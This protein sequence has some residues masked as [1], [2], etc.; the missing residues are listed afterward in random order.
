MR[1]FL[2]PADLA[3]LIAVTIAA[4]PLTNRL[5]AQDSQPTSS[6]SVTAVVVADGNAVSTP[7]PTP[8]ATS[9]ATPVSTIDFRT[10]RTD[11]ASSVATASAKVALAASVN[12]LRSG[13]HAHEANSPLVI[14]AAAQHASLG[15]SQALM[16]VG[17]AALIT[18][19]I[20]GDDPGTVIMVG[21]AIVGLYGLYQYLQ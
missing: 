3:A 19:A 18:G 1:R 10:L 2:R 15:Q 13:A 11:A 16:I 6:D 5:A 17:A 7:T 4:A 12:G 20:I 9:A 14:T 21:G 8:T